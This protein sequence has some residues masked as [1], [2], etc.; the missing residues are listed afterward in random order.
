[1]NT[2][3]RSTDLWEV[4]TSD[5]VESRIAGELSLD[6]DE[7][8]LDEIDEDLPESSR[9]QDKIEVDLINE[10]NPKVA[11]TVE[12][13]TSVNNAIRLMNDHGMGSVLVTD[14]EGVLVGIFTERDVLEKV[15]FEDIDLKKEP[16]ET[17]MTR[18]PFA[19]KAD[20]PIRNALH[21]MSAH[22]FR[23][24]PL[25]SEEHKPVGIISFRDVIRYLRER[26]I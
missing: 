10:L 11:I 16:V 12:E 8:Y 6:M 25:I 14:K 22:G 18:E 24:L 15:A 7:A 20:M 1:M 23:H 26:F 5:E 3:Y 4:T 13:K 2:L 9:L 19:L 21:L 17:Y